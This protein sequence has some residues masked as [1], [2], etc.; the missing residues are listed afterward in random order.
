[1]KKKI[2]FVLFFEIKAKDFAKNG[3][4]KKTYLIKIKFLI[5]FI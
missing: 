3:K 5:D 1:M 2:V 4:N